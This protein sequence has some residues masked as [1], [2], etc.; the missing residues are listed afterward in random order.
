MKDCLVLLTKR[1]PYDSGEEFIENEIPV[2]ARAF[3]K[4]ILIAVAVSDSPVQT[5]EVP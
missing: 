2:L 4:I 1:Y 3:E 5:R